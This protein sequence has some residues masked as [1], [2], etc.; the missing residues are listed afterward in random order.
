MGLRLRAMGKIWVATE[1][2]TKMNWQDWV[3]YLLYGAGGCF[4]GWAITRLLIEALDRAAAAQM[5]SRP[6]SNR[7]RPYDPA[8]ERERSLRAELDRLT[9]DPEISN[10]LVDQ[11]YARNRDKTRSWCLQKAILDIERDRR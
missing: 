10:R 6:P 1:S 2:Q 9:R 8:L 3:L 7:P 11:I 5:R 4:G